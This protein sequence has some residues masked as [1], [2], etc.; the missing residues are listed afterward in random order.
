[1]IEKF[2]A[3]K[4][5]FAQEGVILYYHGAISH[6]LVVEIAAIVKHRMEI[7]DVEASTMLR[8]F[9]AV[10]EQLQNILFY[11]DEIISPGEPQ[12]EDR[13]MRRGVVLVGQEGEHYYVIGGNLIHNAKIARLRG[14]LQSVQHMDKD[15]LKQYC[16]EQRRQDPEQTSRGAGLGIIELARKASEPIAYEFAPADGDFS[17]FFLKTII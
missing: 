8:V 5:A 13:E 16:K 9:S 17:Y 11:S 3:L 10:V 7:D 4:T 15:A 14:K 2:I 1:M 6:D 12:T